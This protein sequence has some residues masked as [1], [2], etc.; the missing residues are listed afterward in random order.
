[1]T[2]LFR[3]CTTLRKLTQLHAHLLVSGSLHSSLHLFRS[4]PNPDPFMWGVL[5]KCFLRNRH[6]RHVISLYHQM[7]HH[8]IPMTRFI[9]PSV[10]R[11]CSGCGELILGR[12]VHGRIVKCGYDEDC[13]VETA[14][15]G[16]YG[17][18]GRLGDA[19]KVFDEMSVRDAVS[20]SSVILSCVENGEVGWRCFEGWC[21]KGLYRIRLPCSVWPRLVGSWGGGG[22]SPQRIFQSNVG[23]RGTACWTAMISCYNQGGCYAEA[24][25]VFGGMQECGVWP[26]SVTLMCVLMSCVGLGLLREGKSVHGFV[27]RK[28]VDPDLD[29]VGS[30]L[31]E[32]YAETGGVSYCQNIL[33]M[34]GGRNVVQW[35]TII[36]V[37]CQKGLLRE[38]LLLFVRIQAHGLMPDSFSMSSAL[39]ACGKMG[40]LELGHQIHGHIVKR[41][42]LDEFVLNSLIDM[43]SKCGFVDS[44]YVIF[45]TMKHPGII[46][47]NSM[48]SGFSS[49]GNSVMAI[50]LFDQI[51]LNRLEIDE[52]TILSVIQAC[53]ELGYLEK[54]KWVHHR[55][56]TSC[57]RKDLFI[58]TALTDMYA[59]CGDLQS[60]QGVFDTMIERSVV[61]W[62]VM[63]AAY[64]MHGKIHAAISLFSQMLET[65]I[66]PNEVTFMNIL[67]ACSH[68]GAVEEGRL[69]FRS[70]RDFGIEPNAEHFACI[71]DLLSRAGDLNGAYD[72]IKSIPVSVDASIWGALLNGCRIHQRMDMIKRIEKDLLD[73]TTDDT[74]Y[75]TL[76]SNLYAEGGNWEEFGNVRLMMKGIGLRKVPGYSVIEIDK[77]VNRFGAGDTPLPQMKEIYRYLNSCRKH[78]MEP[79]S[80]VLSWFTEAKVQSSQNEKCSITVLLD[81]LKDADILPLKDVLMSSDSSHIHAVDL[82]LEFHSDLGTES[83]VDLMNG[84][85]AKLRVVDLQDL[86]LGKEFLRDLCRASLACQVF[87]LRSIH[88]QKLDM[89]GSFLRLHTLNLDFCTSL[90]SLRRDCFSCMP[91]LTRLSICE[92]RISNLLTTT[93]ALS[94]LPCL[95]ELRFQSCLCCKGPGSCP[96]LEGQQKLQTE[97]QEKDETL[98]SAGKKASRNASNTL[99]NFVTHHPSPI[100]FEKH[101]RE[102]IISSLPGLEVLD[103][104]PIRTTEREL[105]KMKSAKY[106]EYLPYKRLHKESVVSVLNKREMGTSGIH[107]QKPFKPKQLYHHRNGQNFF[108][109]SLCAAKLGSST[110]PLLHPLC[111]FN[112]TCKAENKK[113]RPRQFEYHPSNP[114]LM[115]FG[116]LDGEV[117]V[118]NHENGK[119]VGYIPCIGAMSSI[120]GLCWLN[121]SPSKLVAGSDNGSLKLLDLNNMSP[122]VADSCCSSSG[123]PFEDFEQLT[124]LHVNSTDDQLLASGYSKGVALY[125]VGSG[126]HL[127]LFSNLHREPINVAKFAHHSPYLFATSSFDHD[128][129]MWDLR[130]SIRKPCYT[131]SSSRG[132][133]MACFSPDDHYLLVSAVDNEVKQLLVADG[134]L[135]TSFEIASTGSPQNYTRSYYMNGRDYI[136]SGS[137]NEDVVCICC[138]Q[139]GK[140]LR[141]VYLE[142]NS[143]MRFVIVISKARMLTIASFLQDESGSSIFV[144]SLRGDPFRHFNMSILATATRPSFKWEIIK[145][146][147]LAS[148]DY[149]EEHCYG[150][151]LQPSCCLGG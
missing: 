133:V 9:F 37:Y 48:I 137:C 109:R 140:R 128:V 138:A 2:P 10:V 19:R 58:D 67:S 36:S 106:F 62:S 117:V 149:A 122:E 97:S 126:R 8:L 12:K 92:T 34:I 129:K 145:V 105:A 41:G 11:A 33:D 150:Q 26:N 82:F 151:C 1:M 15:L 95:L 71:V 99:K 4:F 114:S 81:Q 14:L 54:G 6:F 3:S 17:E 51:Y 16:L 25:D 139:T 29:F 73:I 68:S 115:V 103:N 55:L 72:I 93:G 147:L 89:V 42:Y 32:L 101:Y 121:K 98:V 130:Q 69:Y 30:A 64:G 24:L 104:F 45:D 39:A 46:T 61:S 21:W 13:V 18:L 90:G 110:W 119:M 84:I 120:L 132:N 28:G 94:R 20:W 74:G 22:E 113:L 134:R 107:F 56:L 87:N 83:V 125:D 131:A 85:N 40:L 52:V 50:S 100:C 66:E 60:A 143:Y 49:S 43:Y 116:T 118:T 142:V 63:I 7:L 123:A 75:Y 44:A 88:I 23:C 65:G 146:N 80:A 111:N 91:N 70:M 124:S 86:S 78:E 108:L 53:S 136:I 148:S 144:Q 79:N 57:M 102:Y 127:Q 112:H 76:F 47:W 27:I 5:I 96:G 77:Q 31:L 35:N 59:K 135:H 38:A 141:D